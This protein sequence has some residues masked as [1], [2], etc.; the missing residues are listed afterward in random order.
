M[1]VGTLL[2]EAPDEDACE[3][4]APARPRAWRRASGHAGGLPQELGVVFG[5][6]GQCSRE[7]ML[8]VSV[9]GARPSLAP[10]GLRCGAAVCGARGLRVRLVRR[11][12]D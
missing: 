5:C 6:L 2:K 1:P 3:G 10:H 7:I 8:G 4:P 11:S 12:I 9:L